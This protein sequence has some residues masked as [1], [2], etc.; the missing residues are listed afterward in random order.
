[1]QCTLDD[2]YNQIFQTIGKIRQH[3]VSIVA[4]PILGQTINHLPTTH[5]SA[6]TRQDWRF[7][8]SMLQQNSSKYHLCISTHPVCAGQK[9]VGFGRDSQRPVTQKDS[10]V[11]LW[12]RKQGFSL[13]CD[14]PVKHP[15]YILPLLLLSHLLY[16]KNIR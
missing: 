1:V 8:C 9:V 16:M 10:L 7:I 14:S 15:E 3:L 4:N 12:D 5:H 13:E 2:G 6:R 11:K